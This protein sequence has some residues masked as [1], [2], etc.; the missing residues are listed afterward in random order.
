M[1]AAITLLIAVFLFSGCDIF[2]TREAEQPSS[3]KSTFIQ[4]VEPSDVIINLKSALQDLNV[5]NY[6]ACFTDSAFSN[7][8]YRFSPSSVAL[9]QF[10]V[11]LA[12]WGK[13]EER[14][15]FLNL[16]NKIDEQQPVT[17]EFDKE[18]FGSPQGDSIVFS[19]SYLLDVPHSD[20]D[21]PTIFSGDLSFSMVR[22]SRNYW[23]IYYWRDSKSGELQS[24]SELKGRFY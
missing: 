10:P 16:K 2:D 13:A 5:E 24:W 14:E 17:L 3:P 23:S 20:P 22:D 18:L 21:I 11:M 15:Y 7:R 8:E 6:L 4:P 9:S 12:G 19:A 1:K